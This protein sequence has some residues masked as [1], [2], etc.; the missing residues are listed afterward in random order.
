M[1]RA[2]C[3]PCQHSWSPREVSLEGAW[4]YMFREPPPGHFCGQFKKE[5]VPTASEPNFI[6][7]EPK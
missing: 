2:D 1:D 7:G 4:C 5:R 6:Q 3:K